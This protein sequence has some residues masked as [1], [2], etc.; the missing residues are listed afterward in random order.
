V[1]S[2]LLRRLTDLEASRAPLGES[3]SPVTNAWIEREVS[4]LKEKG[5]HSEPDPNDEGWR[6]VLDLLKG[7]PQ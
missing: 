5:L 2:A 1:A 7:K 4:T 6:I 3:V